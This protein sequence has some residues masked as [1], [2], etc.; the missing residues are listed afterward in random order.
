MQSIWSHVPWSSEFIW[1]LEDVFNFLFNLKGD[2]LTDKRC[3]V[4]SYEQLLEE[5]DTLFVQAF[6][7]LVP[8]HCRLMN[9]IKP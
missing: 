2:Y 9:I 6:M 3:L 4:G 8:R 7:L 1:F 5:Q